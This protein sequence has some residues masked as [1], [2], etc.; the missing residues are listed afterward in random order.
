MGKNVKTYNLIRVLGFSKAQEKVVV[1]SDYH[2]S[3][4]FWCFNN[5]D[6][7]LGDCTVYLYFVLT[8]GNEKQAN[9]RTA[10]DAAV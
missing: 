10:V 5:F 7:R 3:G 2:F 9:K 8:N 6:R 1:S 4:S